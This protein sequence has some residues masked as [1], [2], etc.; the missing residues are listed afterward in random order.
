[1]QG[2]EIEIIGWAGSSMLSICAVPQVIRTWRTRKANDLSWG[3]LLLWFFGEIL[4]LAYILY[5]DIES[6][7]YHFPLYLNYVFNIILVV[8]LMYARK[9]YR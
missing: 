7:D 3:F 5:S 6:G 8:Y 1:M 2:T 4:T 9:F